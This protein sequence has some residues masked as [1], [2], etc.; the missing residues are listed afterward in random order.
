[1]RTQPLL[2]WLVVQL[3]TNVNANTIELFH[4]FASSKKDNIYKSKTTQA[5]TVEKQCHWIILF[6]LHR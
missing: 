5:L 6:E 2:L 3:P 1:M 4:R